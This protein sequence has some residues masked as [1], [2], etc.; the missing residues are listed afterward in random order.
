MFCEASTW[1]GSSV[2]KR[3]VS[4]QDC[5]RRVFKILKMYKGEGYDAVEYILSFSE[6][7]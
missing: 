4:T 7:Y 1:I 6:Q 2:M 3:I 5:W